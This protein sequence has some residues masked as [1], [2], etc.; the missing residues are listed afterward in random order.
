MSAEQNENTWKDS[1][2]QNEIKAQLKEWT[3]TSWL[4]GQTFLA[5]AHVF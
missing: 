5:G 2:H 3:F 4:K 1:I